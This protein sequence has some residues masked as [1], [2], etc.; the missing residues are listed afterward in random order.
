MNNNK[1]NKNKTVI[2]FASENKS[3]IIPSKREEDGGFDIYANFE[4]EYL[5]LPPQQ[6][7]MIPTG[8]ASAFSADYRIVLKERGSTGSKGMAV[9]AGVIDSGFRGFWFVAIS[10]VTDNHIVIAKNTEQAKQ[11]FADDT[12][13]Y[14][15]SKAI[16]QALI[17]ENP[18]AVV[19]TVSYDM[20]SSIS[21]ERGMEQLG[22][23]GK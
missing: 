6:V 5:V 23:S 1:N 12:V 20:L 22:Q 11:L 2:L 16:C 15:Y 14:P 4:D 18:K 10:N 19:K 7:T 8:L 17:E 13:I 3:V 21:S 9:R